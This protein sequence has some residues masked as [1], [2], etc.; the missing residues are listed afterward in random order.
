MMARERRHQQQELKQNNL[1]GS[2]PASVAKAISAIHVSEWLTVMSLVFAGCCSNIYTL[3][4][5]VKSGSGGSGHLITLAQFGFVAAEGLISNLEFGWT[6]NDYEKTDEGEKVLRERKVWVPIRLRKRTVPLYIWATM[7]VL[8]FSASV[9]NNYALSFKVPMPVHIIFRSASLLFSL[10]MGIVVF[11]QKYTF[12]QIFGVLLVTAGVISSTY[13]SAHFHPSSNSQ[14]SPLSD[15]LTGISMLFLALMLSSLLG[16]IQQITYDKYGRAQW[17]EALFY[18]HFLALPMFAV[19]WMDIQTQIGE[20]SK[21]EG[22][23]LRSVAESLGWGAGAR[24]VFDGMSN[25]APLFD[26]EVPSMWM[27]LILN[28]LTQYVC[29]SGVHK[30]SSVASP[31]TLNLVLSIR[32]LVSLLISVHVFRNEGPWLGAFAVFVGTV[33]YLAGG[34]RKGTR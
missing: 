5:L 22:V 33:V 27:N 7:V 2:N 34:Q 30:L 9:L 16:Y 13:T 12:A 32:K 14:Q 15:Y 8:F 17:R 10:L 26:V 24:S 28:M 21:S 18:T 23:T 19:F 1:N 31:V 4:V 29:I 25:I 11:R 6:V 3:E 20:Y